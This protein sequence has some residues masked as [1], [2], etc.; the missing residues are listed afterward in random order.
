MLP[1]ESK[2]EDIPQPTSAPRPKVSK[3]KSSWLERRFSKY[4]DNSVLD[5]TT[6]SQFFK[7][8]DNDGSGTLSFEELQVL[9]QGV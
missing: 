1:E 9:T 4:D 8:Y 5:D 3:I 6:L 7:L 2:H